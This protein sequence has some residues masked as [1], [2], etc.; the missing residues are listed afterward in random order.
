METWERKVSKNKVR[1]WR[2][3]MLEV[4]RPNLTRGKA[5]SDCRR[6]NMR[7]NERAIQGEEKEK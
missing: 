4:L 1:W 5:R 3:S 7:E 6:R 2:V